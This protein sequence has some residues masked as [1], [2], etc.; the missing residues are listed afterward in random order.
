MTTEW[1]DV[2][3]TAGTQYRVEFDFYAI[4]S[5]ETF[6]EFCRKLTLRDVRV[7]AP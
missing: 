3:T 4:D 7:G 6:L 1:V 5:W 2:A